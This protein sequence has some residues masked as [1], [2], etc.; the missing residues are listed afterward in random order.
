MP[1]LW[2]RHVSALDHS[3]LHC[4]SWHHAWKA[5]ILQACCH[6]LLTAPSCDAHHVSF[7]ARLALLHSK[8]N[9]LLGTP[10]FETT[11][12]VP[13]LGAIHDLTLA[14]P[15][16]MLSQDTGNSM[17]RPH[18]APRGCMNAHG[19]PGSN[20]PG[21]QLLCAALL[22]PLEGNCCV[23]FSPWKATAVWT[24]VGCSWLLLM[25]TGSAYSRT[26]SSI[27]LQDR[28]TPSPCRSRPRT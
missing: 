24:V 19:S 4:M 8:A 9:S 5:R 1:C 16:C 25:H 2:Q 28:L 23:G 12:T 10:L 26:D 18:L 13:L 20:A 14:Q 7:Q 21:A 11:L 17:H 15:Q 27:V 3:T 22:Q 6:T